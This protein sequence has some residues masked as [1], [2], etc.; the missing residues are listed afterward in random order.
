[1]RP[2]IGSHVPPLS[3]KTRFLETNRTILAVVAIQWTLPSPSVL[4]GGSL[5][6]LDAAAKGPLGLVDG[7]GCLVV[8]LAL[9]VVLRSEEGPALVLVGG[10]I[11]DN[12]VLKIQTYKTV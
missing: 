6:L 10:C 11:Q 8:L 2:Y 5:P 4:V 3:L 12:L 1:M 7:L 9:L